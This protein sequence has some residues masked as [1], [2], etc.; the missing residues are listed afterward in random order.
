MYSSIRY[1]CIY[2]N[3][4]YVQA[5]YNAFYIHVCAYFTFVSMIVYTSKYIGARSAA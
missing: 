3:M 5:V 1:V 4:E 2:G